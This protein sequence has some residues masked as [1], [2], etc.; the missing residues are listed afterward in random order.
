MPNLN[1]ELIPAMV[2]PFKRD[3]SV[4][5]ER[6]AQLAVYLADNG[7]DGILVNG[8]TGECPTLSLEEKLELIKV[9]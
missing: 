9:V 5:Y 2:T 7:C 4:D 8:T 1:A 3:E 6:A